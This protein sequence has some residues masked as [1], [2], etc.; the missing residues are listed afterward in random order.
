MKVVIDQSDMFT[1]VFSALED[2]K[3][4]KY[5]FMVAAL[6]EYIRSLSEN[7]IT[8]QHYLYEMIINILVRNNCFYQ[9]HQFLQ[10]HVLQDSK[11]LACLMLSLESVY[12]PAHQLA[13]D[14]LKRL[15][16]ANEE[17]IEV[18]LSKQQLLPALRFI[19]SVNI[20]ES[21]SSRKF[22]EAAMN[23]EDAMLFYTVFKF[24]EQRNV[25]MRGNPKFQP[26]EHCEM[27]VKQ[28]ESLFGTDALAEMVLAS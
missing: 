16:T 27:Y 22:L 12:P 1:H 25:K 14:M 11:P 24:F 19:R 8:V 21:V 13:L 17:I 23:T 9:L 15:S 10:Y 6:I 4:L 28:F 3:N 5:K 2:N 26:G 18:L 20:V 7:N